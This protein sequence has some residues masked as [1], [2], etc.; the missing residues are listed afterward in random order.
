MK[1]NK[2][3][4]VILALIL[5]MSMTA[6][7]FADAG[8]T[9]LGSVNVPGN[10]VEIGVTG[11]YSNETST[12]ATVYSVDVAWGAMSFTYKVT[13]TGT[14]N[15]TTHQYDAN[16]SSTGTWAVDNDESG[17]PTNVITLTNHSNAPVK[18]AFSFTDTTSTGITGNFS[19][20]D[21]TLAT[22]VETTREAAP[23]N[24]S[25]LTLSNGKLEST[26]ISATSI[27]TVTVTLS[28]AS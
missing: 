4:V 3:F 9:T 1:T 20:S 28:A 25:A 11:K 22:A 21:F 18:A 10:S 27:G 16:E 15:P 19:K 14:W 17:N 12:G 7:A 6:T 13:G 8:S 2:L 5:T 26:N 23:T 24:N